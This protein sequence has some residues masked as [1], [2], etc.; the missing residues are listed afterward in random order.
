MMGHAELN[1]R[2]IDEA[3]YSN[4]LKDFQKKTSV[5]HKAVVNLDIKI[6]KWSRVPE[7]LSDYVQAL[8]SKTGAMND[9]SK[10]FLCGKRV[11]G[12]PE[13]MRTVIAALTELSLDVPE[14][15][16]SML[17]V[18]SIRD[19]VRFNQV[20]DIIAMFKE[21]AGS[22]DESSLH[23]VEAAA[24]AIKGLALKLPS[25][26]KTRRRESCCA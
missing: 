21:A 15:W 2:M 6:K 18:E 1:R 12:N 10:T 22:T 19:H 4:A 25:P 24:E 8:R 16:N 26:L 13:K 17:L 14:A 20:D 9:A 3:L 5:A 23:L 11:G 7:D